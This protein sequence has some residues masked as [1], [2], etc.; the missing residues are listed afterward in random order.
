MKNFFAFNAKNN[1]TVNTSGFYIRG[2]NINL[3]KIT[4]PPF[5][6]VQS[7]FGN[8]ITYNIGGENINVILK[9]GFYT[10]ISDLIS[11]VQ[12]YLQASN[13]NFTVSIEDNT[14]LVTITNTVTFSMTGSF[15][16][17]YLGFKIDPG[18]STT[19][20]TS[21]YSAK[22][23]P[24]NGFGVKLSC[25]NSTIQGFD[26]KYQFIL[27]SDLF[28]FSDNKNYSYNLQDYERIN[29][30]NIFGNVLSSFDISVYVLFIDGISK[31]IDF[32]DLKI[33]GILAII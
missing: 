20:F 7:N 18:G 12:T 22:L 33:L 3:D 29:T 1:S 28:S 11:M 31:L 14:N 32:Q 27:P 24:F 19:T 2:Q 23:Y 5:M 21:I 13:P 17:N 9:S 26:Q 6:N 25:I 10:T 4:I 8:T 16:K 15:I 30:K